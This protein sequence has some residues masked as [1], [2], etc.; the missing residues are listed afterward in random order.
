[1]RGGEQPRWRSDGRE[2]F[3]L[4]PDGKIM[5]TPVTTGASFDAETPVA[6]FQAYPRE[7]IATSEQFDYDIS[8]DGQRFLINTQL[9][10][11]L[12]PMSVVMNWAASL[13]K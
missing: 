13:N 4:A 12:T 9:K 3:Y 6:L 5:G 11:A 10:A 7:M 1:M 8:K 2:L